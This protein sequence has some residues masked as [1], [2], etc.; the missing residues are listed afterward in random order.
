MVRG[1]NTFSML[2]QSQ[3]GRIGQ[4]LCEWCLNNSASKPES[5]SGHHDAL[6]RPAISLQ[7]GS[8]KHWLE[9]L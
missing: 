1:D 8:D 9:K 4:L 2:K 3:P 7:C 5:S 6:V